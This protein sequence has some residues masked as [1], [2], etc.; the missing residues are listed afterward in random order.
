MLILF[1]LDYWIFEYT[2]FK[3]VSQERVCVCWLV[4]YLSLPKSISLFTYKFQNLYS[5]E[6]K[7]SVKEDQKK[8][9]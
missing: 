6:Y 2:Y 5:L 8:N 7:L 4:E 9:W 3:L 1:L